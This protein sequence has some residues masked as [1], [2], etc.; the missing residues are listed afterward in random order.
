MGKP[1]Y[2]YRKYYSSM[3]KREAF[4]AAEEFRRV[5]IKRF[6]AAKSGQLKMDEFRAAEKYLMPLKKGASYNEAK[7]RVAKLQAFLRSEVSTRRGYEDYVRRGSKLMENALGIHVLT[8]FSEDTFDPDVAGRII[9]DFENEIVARVMSSTLPSDSERGKGKAIQMIIDQALRDRDS[10]I[11]EEIQ[12]VQVAPGVYR[13]FKR[14]KVKAKTDRL[15]YIDELLDK[16][17][18]M[19]GYAK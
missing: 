18:E 4:E 7:A 3:T 10:Y 13:P 8:G 17:K 6:R 12:E 5:A 19:Y 1:K 2:D 15:G 14:L 16:W 11:E 9:S